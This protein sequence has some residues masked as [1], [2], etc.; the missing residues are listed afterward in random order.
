MFWYCGSLV[1]ITKLYPMVVHH[2]ASDLSLAGG[3]T[4]TVP[5]LCSAL[6]NQGINV[7]LHALAPSMVDTRNSYR[8]HSH[9]RTRFLYKLGI[10]ES[11][12][13]ALSTATTEAD[14]IHSHLLWQMPTI[15]PGYVLKGGRSRCKLVMSPRGTLD[16]WD[17]HNHALQKRLVW[18]AG[19]RMN[20]AASA[21]LHATAPMERDH[22]RALGFTGPVAIIPNGV[23]IPEVAKFA[24]TEDGKHRLLF[25]ARIHRKKGLDFLLRAWRN[26][27]DRAKDWELQIAGSPNGDHL[28]AMRTLAAELGV[29]RVSFLCPITEAQKWQLY[30]NA[31][32]YVLPTRGDN[33]AVTISDA[34]SFGVPAIVSKEAPWQGLES[35]DCGWWIDL[36]VDALTDCLQVALRSDPAALREKG[37]RGRQWM[38]REFSWSEVGRMMTATYQWIVTGGAAPQWVS[39]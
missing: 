8:F 27:Q 34:L 25:L 22:F 32:L 13:K 35:N 17:F 21:C 23:D 29:E 12:R 1:T 38:E 39:L 18:F 11:M 5:A 31:D 19:Q 26:I 9:R 7:T 6:S 3:P 4:Y 33:W 15:Y 2:V 24:R 14:I 28:Q 30:R 37:E 10:S 20:L 16:P 36:T